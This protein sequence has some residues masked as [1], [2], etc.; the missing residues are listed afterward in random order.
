MIA[1]TI[2]IPFHNRHRY[3]ERLF[4]GLSGISMDNVEIVFV[5][6]NSDLETRVVMERLCEKLSATTTLTVSIIRETKNGSAAAR[7]AGLHIAKGEY[8]YFFDSDD[9]FSPEFIPVAYGKAK[10]KDFDAVAL[11]TKIVFPDGKT[12]AKKMLRSSSPAV[13]I[14]CN[15]FATQSLMVKRSFALD[16]ALW[17]EALFYWNDLEWGLRILIARPK[18]VWLKGC[19][20]RIYLHTDSITGAGFADRIDKIICAHKAIRRDIVELMQSSEQTK[21]LKSLNCRIAIYA[22]HVYREASKSDALQLLSCID[23]TVA[24]RLHKIKLSLLYC[25][26]RRGVPG[27][28]RIALMHPLEAKF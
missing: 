14:V 19:Y 12:R 28:W 26:S 2:V 4:D 9:E 13:Q 16:N 6:N 23:K 27:L 20:H 15:N 18:M 17:N 21:L 22:G 10:E 1:V 24:S 8:V 11:R 5:D 3:F 25:L 7:N